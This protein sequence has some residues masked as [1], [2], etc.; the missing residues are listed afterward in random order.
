M[1]RNFHLTI[2]GFCEKLI[3][4]HLQSILSDF[5]IPPVLKGIYWEIYVCVKNL[6]NI[7]M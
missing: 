1:K 4:I 2:I 3:K 7:S 5:F 6:F